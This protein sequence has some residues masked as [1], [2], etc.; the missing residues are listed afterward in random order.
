MTSTHAKRCQ[1]PAGLYLNK[2]HA[3]L[4]IVS[5]VRVNSVP[6]F[7]IAPILRESVPKVNVRKSITQMAASITTRDRN[8][9]IANSRAIAGYALLELIVNI[10]MM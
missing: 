7:W 10:E 6:I 5:G 8:H 9:T 3:V 2:M 4:V 1:H